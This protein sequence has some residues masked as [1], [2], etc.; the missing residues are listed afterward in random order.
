[1]NKYISLIVAIEDSE[2]EKAK[3]LINELG[4]EANLDGGTALNYAALYGNKEIFDYLINANANVDALFEGD[5]SSLMAAADRGDEY[6]AKVLLN[7]GANI[8][9]IDR[10]GNSALKYAGTK[11]KDKLD[12]IKLFLEHGGNPWQKNFHGNSL[13]DVAKRR[14]SQ[15]LIEL[16]EQYP[17]NFPKEAEQ[18]TSNQETFAGDITN[19]DAVLKF[20]WKTLVPKNGPAATIQG[21]L[22]SAVEKIRWE[23]SNNGGVNWDKRFPQRGQFIK[24]NLINSTILT[25]SEKKTIKAAITTILKAKGGYYKDDLYDLLCDF[26][27]K[28]YINRKEL[29]LFT[30]PADYD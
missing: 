28:F 9:L 20:M 4:I 11:N 1:M 25:E 24:T 3:A 16:I 12:F 29:I 6:I 8:N 14:D 13:M 19:K 30:P 21:E 23:C 17:D 10:H 7:K 15:E 22:L 2:N 18:K 26:I 27:Y 5:Y